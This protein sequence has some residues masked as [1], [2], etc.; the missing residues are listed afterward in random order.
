MSFVKRQLSI[1]FQLQ[2]GASNASTQFA[3]SGTDTASL[4]NLR[5]SAKIVKSGDPTLNSLQLTVYGMTLS[6]MNQ[7][8]TLGKAIN[9]LRPAIVTVQAGDAQA[10]MTTVFKGN[11]SNAYGDFQNAPDVPFHVEA[12]SG[13]MGGIQKMDP[14]SFSGSTDA[15]TVMQQC[16]SKMGLSFENN[17]VNQKLSNPYFYGSPRAQAQS[18]AAAANIGFAIDDDTLAIYPKNKPRNGGTVTVSPTTGMIS[19]PTFTNAG[20]LVRTLF[21]PQIKFRSQIEI[22]S[23]LQRANGTWIVYGLSHDLESQ[24]IKGQWFSTL[25]CYNPNQQGGA[26]PLPKS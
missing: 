11:V 16:A 24:V 4:N 25:E 19:Y 2:A 13:L 14:T 17:N 12:Y 23:S 3:E 9:L 10:G 20:I 21:N 5:M 1:S 26:P 7:L 8:S 15:S 22:Q 18:C 6:L